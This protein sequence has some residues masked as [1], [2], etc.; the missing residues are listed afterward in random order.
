MKKINK[1]F[2]MFLKIFEN[3]SNFFQFSALVKEWW[4]IIHFSLKWPLRTNNHT[5]TCCQKMMKQTTNCWDQ[6]FLFI[7]RHTKVSLW[8]KKSSHKGRSYSLNFIC[9]WEPFSIQC[10]FIWIFH[11]IIRHGTIFLN[12]RL[13]SLKNLKSTSKPKYQLLESQHAKVNRK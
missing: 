7:F 9:K 10:F 12:L 8:Q 2:T 13:V 4:T 6:T 1:I 11:Q 5:Q 3:G